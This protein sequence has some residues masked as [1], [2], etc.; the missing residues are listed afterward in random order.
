MGFVH[1]CKRFAEADMDLKPEVVETNSKG[2][3]EVHYVP[4]G[5]VG[6]ITP[7]NFPLDMACNKLLPSVI[8]GNTVVLKPSPYTPLS[9]VMLSKIAAKTMPPGVMNILS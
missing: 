1:D 6:G 3:V 4:R 8:T 2:R 7:W 5:V 9:T